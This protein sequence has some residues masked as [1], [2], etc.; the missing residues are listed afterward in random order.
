MRRVLESSIELAVVAWA[1]SN[2]FL[3][4][5]MQYVGRRGCPDRLFVGYGQSIWME[6]KRPGGRPDPL[7]AREHLRFEDAGVTVHVI[8]NVEE[9]IEV[10]RFAKARD[11]SPLTFG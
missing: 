2:G 5:K 1:E 9:G 6:F 10:L 11:V 8:D 3:S 4:R 7:Q